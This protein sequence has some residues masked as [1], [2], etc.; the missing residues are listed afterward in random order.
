[1]YR[2]CTNK[3]VELFIQQPITIQNILY[4]RTVDE[5]KKYLEKFEKLLD[6]IPDK[7]HK[8]ILDSLNNY[9]NNYVDN[10]DKRGII[11]LF[12]G[13]YG[14]L[15]E[16]NNVDF[17]KLPEGNYAIFYISYNFD[18]PINYKYKN[19][20][21]LTNIFITKPDID[22]FTPYFVKYNIYKKTKPFDLIDNNKSKWYVCLCYC[23]KPK[24]TE[25]SY[26]ISQETF[27][28]RQIKVLTN[29]G[30]IKPIMKIHEDNIAMYT[31]YEDMR[32]SSIKN[33]FTNVKQIIKSNAK[34][35]YSHDYSETVNN[36]IN[37]IKH[38][39][40]LNKKFPNNFYKALAIMIKYQ[41][42]DIW[43][44]HEGREQY[45]LGVFKEFGD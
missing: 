38:M 13:F 16:N 42:Y 4:D 25:C 15:F 10:Y 32:P 1:M 37:F 35:L 39:M 12:C 9:L 33:E 27:T 40:T 14:I 20:Y 22:N 44:K 34:R 41:L 21:S 5:A 29:G 8:L 3:E 31:R 43:S 45:Y 23:E 24:Y 26:R 28:E 36:W 30:F 6:N 18:K 7:P 2:E 19:D 17:D 11:E